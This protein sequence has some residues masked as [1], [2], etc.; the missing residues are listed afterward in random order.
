MYKNRKVICF[1]PARGGSKGLPRKNILTIAGKPL[2]AYSINTA[3]K[4]KYI[5]K[6]FVSTEDE[7][8]KRISHEYGAEVIDRPTE[9]ASDTASFLDVVKHMISVIPETKNAV[10]VLFW[11]TTPI[12][13]IEHIERCIELFDENIDC[14]VS[15]MEAK[16]RP[17]WLLIQ[18]G[19]LLQFWQKGIPEPNRQQQKETFFYMNGSVVVTSSDFLEKQK[20]VIIGD[21]MKGY[22]MDE[23]HSLDIDTKFDFD[24]CKLIIESSKI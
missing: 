17:S 4:V 12:R 6:I 1:I 3:K 18:K 19:N 22:L 21:K 15:V 7:E 14:V 24:L 11:V 20:D 2:I 5:D 10:I 13:K 8:I 23:K 16:I 9:L